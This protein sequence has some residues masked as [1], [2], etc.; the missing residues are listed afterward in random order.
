MALPK[1]RNTLDLNNNDIVN[2]AIIGTSGNRVDKIWTTD[3]DITNFPTGGGIASLNLA[4]TFTASQRS[5]TTTL[6]DAATIDIDLALS[7]NFHLVLGGNRTLGVPTNIVAGQSGVINVWQDIVG[8]RTLSYAWP[9]V[10]SNGLLPVLS[11][12]KLS[13]DQIYYTVSYYKTATVTITIASP[14]VITWTAHGLNSGQRIQLTTT[15]ALPTGLAINTTYW[16]TVID[17]NTFNLS[18]SFINA[19]TATFINTSGSQSG[20]HTATNTSI[21]LGNNAGLA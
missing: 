18:T 17:P 7:N 3:L 12:N 8:G 19:G 21:A 20:V 16:V 5:S 10:S 9:Y 6:T 2:P 1:I 15:G 14:A 4:Q 13:F 11:P